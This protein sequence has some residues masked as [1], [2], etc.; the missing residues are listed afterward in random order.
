MDTEKYMN[1]IEVE[2][3]N[4]STLRLLREMTRWDEVAHGNELEIIAQE[5]STRISLKKASI[6]TFI[7]C[8]IMSN[9]GNAFSEHFYVF[10]EDEK[11]IRRQL[12]IGIL[13]HLTVLILMSSSFFIIHFGITL[14]IISLYILWIIKR[15]LEWYRP[16]HKK[17]NSIST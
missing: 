4:S 14:I 12:K 6:L 13:T 10:D 7:I 1:D 5:I 3:K 8:F 11:E 2:T 15:T 16:L 9:I 17:L